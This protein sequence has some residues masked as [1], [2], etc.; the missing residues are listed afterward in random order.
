MSGAGTAIAHGKVAD[1][2]AIV[3]RNS[4]IAVNI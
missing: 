2:F 3:A 1:F 4:E